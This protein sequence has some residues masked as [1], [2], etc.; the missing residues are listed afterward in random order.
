MSYE[1]FFDFASGL[2]ESIKVPKG[3]M[4]SIL[5]HVDYVESNL[6]IQREKFEDNPEH[7]AWNDYKDIDNKLLC[8]VAEKHNNWVIRMY[9]DIE[10]WQ[11]TPP[12]EFD[13]IT[14]E[15]AQSF[16]P[17]LERITVKPSRWTGDYYTAIMET[18]Y[19]VMR[20]RDCD[21]ISFDQKALT[22]KQAA[23]VINLFSEF[24]DTDD[25][26][27][28][29]PKGQDYLASSYDGGYEWCEKCG[30][31]T[32]EDAMRCNKRKCPVQKEY[33]NE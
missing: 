17:A 24:L 9:R 26:R 12:L 2:S 8:K 15:E 11:K 29:V 25:R 23:Q 5:E 19:E 14:P 28:D 18:L 31:I 6:N 16:F 20:G 3:T 33:E 32:L 4:K 10:K 1:T 7:W 21:G 22:E 13:V 30:A 27:L